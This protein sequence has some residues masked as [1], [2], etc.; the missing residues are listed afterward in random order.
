VRR[1]RRRL[2]GGGGEAGFTLVELLVAA[3]MSVILVGAAGSMLISAVRDQPK[4]NKQSQ[5][6]STARWILERMT[7]EIRNGVA[8]DPESTASKVSFTAYVRHA[9]CDPAAPLS[10]S[11]SAVVCEITY[12]CSSGTACTRT[13]SDP[14]TAGGVTQT[15]FSGINDDEVFSYEPPTGPATFVGVALRFPNPDGTGALTI[16]D[17]ASL[18]TADPFG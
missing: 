3:A 12:D 5:G 6:I 16:S 13:E 7:R 17:G 8:V 18:R 4:L 14:A 10:S 1:L 9:N 11:S 2:S 15:I